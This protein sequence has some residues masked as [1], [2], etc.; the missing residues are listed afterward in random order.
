MRYDD[1][2]GPAETVIEHLQDILVIGL[3]KGFAHP[4]V[5]DE[6]VGAS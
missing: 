6:Q 5:E 3:G 4:V 2:G 1:C